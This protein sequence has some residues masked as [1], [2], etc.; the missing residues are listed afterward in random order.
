MKMTRDLYD[1]IIFWL[2]GDITEFER[3]MLIESIYT[4]SEEN[5]RATINVLTYNHLGIERV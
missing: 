2:D 4:G 3:R 5:I 1:D